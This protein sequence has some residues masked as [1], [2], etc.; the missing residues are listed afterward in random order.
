[1]KKLILRISALI[2]IT[3]V[4]LVFFLLF[5]QLSYARSTGFEGNITIYHTQELAAE[6][7]VI[8]G[9]SLKMA[10][11]SEIYDSNFSI[12]LCLDD[13]P[14]FPHFM[15]LVK[16]PALGFGYANKVAIVCKVDFGTNKAHLHGKTWNLSGLIAHEMIH[17]HQF[18]VFGFSSLNTPIWK[19]EGY[20]EYITR[21]TRDDAD[22][23]IG[24]T[25]FIQLKKDGLGDWDW[26][27][28][29]DGNGTLANYFKARLLV[30]Y[31]MEIEQ[32]TYKE[33]LTDDRNEEEV[34]NKMLEWFEEKE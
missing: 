29:N 5:P 6:Y 34:E 33:I 26:V 22:L 12:D 30:Q 31:L 7:Q 13:G 9:E 32:M 1:M 20:P 28:S 27:E 25:K 19:Q 23:K 15:E 3:L 2:L 17:C 14:Y 8:L 10:Q 18:N 11:S 21:I 16:G 24:L 4:S